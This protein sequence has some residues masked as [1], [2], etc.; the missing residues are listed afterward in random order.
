MA[1]ELARLPRIATFSSKTPVERAAFPNIEN[2][3]H[4]EANAANYCFAQSDAAEAFANFGS[5]KEK[6][7]QANKKNSDSFR[8]ASNK[9]HQ[10]MENR[11]KENGGSCK[12]LSFVNNVFGPS[13][14][15]NTRKNI[16]KVWR[17]LSF[18]DF[19]VPTDLARFGCP[20]MWSSGLL[21]CSMLYRQQIPSLLFS[22]GSIWHHVD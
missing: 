8:S 10:S 14:S 21:P 13:G 22:M 3:L 18:K 9:S 12:D 16:F 2:V 19:D 7:S 17:Q 15:H 6:V 1:I 20:L 11:P 4:D 5:R